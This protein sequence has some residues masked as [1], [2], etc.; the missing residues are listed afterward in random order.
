M[1]K[2]KNLKKPFTFKKKTCDHCDVSEEKTK[3]AQ[4]AE[5]ESIEK[6]CSGKTTTIA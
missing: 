4:Y 5:P 3:V 1:V 6:L 2:C